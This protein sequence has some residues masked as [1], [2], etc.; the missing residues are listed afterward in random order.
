MDD[1]VTVQRRIQL[2]DRAV[3]GR[4]SHEAPVDPQRSQDLRERSPGVYNDSVVGRAASPATQKTAV[5]DYSNLGDR[6]CHVIAHAARVDATGSGSSMPNVRMP[7]FT[8]APPSPQAEVL[9]GQA[10]GLEAVGL[11]A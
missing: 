3:H 9:V 7:Y 2:D 10:H 4:D 6:T 1:T 8:D 5:R 11:Q